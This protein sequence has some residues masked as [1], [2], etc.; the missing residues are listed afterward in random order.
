MGLEKMCQRW[1]EQFGF[2]DVTVSIRR[3]L[4]R[5]EI[6]MELGLLG[7]EF[8]FF[9]EGVWLGDATAFF[10]F[11]EVLTGETARPTENLKAG[12]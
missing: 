8:D 11:D 9:E 2:Y 6:D 3:V 1:L 4:D 12:I 10:H 5:N 7:V